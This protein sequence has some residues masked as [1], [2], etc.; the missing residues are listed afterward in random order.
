MADM[1]HR[2]GG[3]RRASSLALLERAKPSWLELAYVDEREDARTA[4][5]VVTLDCNDQL[6]SG[7]SP[8][9]KK[10]KRRHGIHRA[11]LATLRAIEIF[12]HHQLACELVDVAC[13]TARSNPLVVARI[14]IVS[15]GDTA[16]LFGVARVE[17]DLAEA[18][19]RAVLDAAHVYVHSLLMEV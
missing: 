5:V 15:E 6:L 7:T 19:A 14:R 13:V 16:E 11:A 10:A 3:Y 18:A 12:A 4:W 8:A 1:D 9:V 17:G 2:V